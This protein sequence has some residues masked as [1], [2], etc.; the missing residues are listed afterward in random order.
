VQ[1]RE[2]GAQGLDRGGGEGGRH[3]EIVLYLFL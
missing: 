2:A 1:G 3:W